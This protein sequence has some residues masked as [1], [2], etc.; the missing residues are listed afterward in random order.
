[1]YGVGMLNL[2]EILHNSQT[3]PFDI[4]D[5]QIV[6]QALLINHLRDS[7]ETFLQFYGEDELMEIV[8]EFI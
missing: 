4:D 2:D 5:Q 8:D 7:V 1:M 3:G 6:D